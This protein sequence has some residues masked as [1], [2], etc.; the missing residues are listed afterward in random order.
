M[1]L[2]TVGLRQENHSVI[3]SFFET[4]NQALE[5]TSGKPLPA[6]LQKPLCTLSLIRKGDVYAEKGNCFEMQLS[7]EQLRIATQ[8]RRWQ[9][10]PHQGE[11]FAFDRQG[12]PN[13]FST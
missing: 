2:M 4:E 9:A 1:S 5:G 10:K 13:F 11:S 12:S 6:T 3:V 7:R 8:N